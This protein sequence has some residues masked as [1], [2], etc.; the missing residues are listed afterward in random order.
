MTGP[1]F[2]RR[3]FLAAG[4]FASLALLTSC[5][6]RAPQDVLQPLGEVARR[7][8]GLWNITFAIAVFVFVVVE[9]V[10]VYTLLRFRHKAG[11]RAAQFHGN[12]RL[13]VI[14]TVIPSLILAGL[15]VPT[16][17][18]ILDLSKDV[19]PGSLQIDVT[20]RQFWWEYEYQDEGIVTA[21]EMH[22]PVG[23]HVQIVLHGEDVIHA[24]WVPRLAGKQDTVPGRINTLQIQA[25]KPGRYMGQCTEFC[26]LSHAN[27][28]LIVFAHPR[29]EYDAWVAEQQREAA[30]PTGS[31]AREGQE[32]FLNTCAVCHAVAGTDAQGRQGPDLTHFMS[33]STFA[34]AMFENNTENLSAWIRNP[35]EM[36][37]GA[38]MPDYG[39]SEDEVRALVA[40]LQSL[41]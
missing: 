1:N 26:G 5:S 30:E 3:R 21:N 10:L 38:K 24:F 8:D 19:P 31:D 22:I 34:G 29:D 32:I 36:K 6:E 17:K 27:M 23:E 33:R 35:P 7:A 18:T 16:V 41:D 4:L 2:Q 12:T 37:P 13:E 11:R 39:L 28:R 20:A 40:Y 9:G 25:D 15:A 14:L